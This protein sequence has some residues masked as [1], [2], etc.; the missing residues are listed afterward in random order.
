MSNRISDPERRIAELLHVERADSFAPYFVN[1]VMNRVGSASSAT[2]QM[3]G[4]SLY[5]A[6][7]WVFVRVALTCLLLIVALGLINAF[8]F[9]VSAT[10]SWVDTLLGLPSDELAD[11]LTYEII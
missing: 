3:N 7:R 5:D 8:D 1:R 4:D 10:A 2:G 6:L 11:V 9:D